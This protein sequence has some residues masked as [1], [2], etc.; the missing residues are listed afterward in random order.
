MVAHLIE[1]EVGVVS[2]WRLPRHTELPC[3]S[4][5]VGTYV[6]WWGDETCG[7]VLGHPQCDSS[8]KA[9]MLTVMGGKRK[10]H[11]G[12]GIRVVPRERLTH[13]IHAEI[14]PVPGAVGGSVQDKNVELGEEPHVLAGEH[15]DLPHP[16]GPTAL[17]E[18]CTRGGCIP[19]EQMGAL[20]HPEPGAS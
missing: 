7:N 5:P 18:D 14:P 16:T 15:T 3:G 11:R 1:E 9:Q 8:C 17:C 19:E 4:C 13:C 20:E 12:V 6:H 10:G 2:K